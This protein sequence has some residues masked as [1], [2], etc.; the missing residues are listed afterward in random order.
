MQLEWSSGIGDPNLIGWVTV[1]CYFACAFQCLR[2]L[3][4]APRI[5][6][7]P[8]RRQKALWGG[9]V[10]LMLFLGINKQLDLQSLLTE[11][12][13]LMAQRQ[14]WYEDRRNVQRVFI[15]TLAGGGVVTGVLLLWFYRSVVRT[16][17]LAIAGVFI[18]T[19]FIVMRASVFHRVAAPFGV[20]KPGLWLNA[21]LEL[22]GILLIGLNA[23]VLLRENAGQDE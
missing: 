10:L 20:P 1:I 15:F 7:A 8:V 11:L 21:A 13:R 17:R 2:V 4:K 16:H 14:G 23:R 9:L 18:L 19:L 5:F 3:A 6:D 22:A 12:G